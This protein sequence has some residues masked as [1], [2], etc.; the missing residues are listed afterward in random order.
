MQLFFY[1]QNQPAEGASGVRAVLFSNGI[2]VS[3][4]LI[5]HT[6]HCSSDTGSG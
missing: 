4:F 6:D 1:E 3:D 2:P 5:P